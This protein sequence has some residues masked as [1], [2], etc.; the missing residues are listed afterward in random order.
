MTEVIEMNGRFREMPD[1]SLQNDQNKTFMMELSES[2]MYIIFA[3]GYRKS[4]YVVC[5]TTY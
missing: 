3:K 4:E 5:R 2:K 1:L